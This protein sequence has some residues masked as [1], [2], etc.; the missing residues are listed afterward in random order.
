MTIG[1]YSKGKLIIL[2]PL[3]ASKLK[4]NTS[5]K[6]VK[7]GRY[8]ND[9]KKN[10]NKKKAQANKRV[11]DFLFVCLGFFFFL[12]CINVALLNCEYIF[13]LA[14]PFPLSLPLW[15][16]VAVYGGK[17]T[18]V[19]RLYPGLLSPALLMEEGM[20]DGG[21]HS[22]FRHIFSQSLIFAFLPLSFLN[23]IPPLKTIT[24]EVAKCF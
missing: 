6:G 10:N 22:P 19:V 21:R 17:L 18:K 3:F 9:N 4:H 5:P 12:F 24:Y 16:I 15:E 13:Q 8:H 2:P 11:C 20:G 14:L 7:V 23:S 1:I